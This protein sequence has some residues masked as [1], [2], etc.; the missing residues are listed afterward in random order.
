MET[1]GKTSV[2]IWK[3]S[4]REDTLA[5]RSLQVVRK[6]LQSLIEERFTTTSS[7][8]MCKHGSIG[9]N[10]LPKKR[11]TTSP[12]AP[13]F[14]TLLWQQS[15]PC[16]TATFK[17][18]AFWTKS[19][20]FSAVQQAQA[21]QFTFKMSF[22]PDCQRRIL[23]QLRLDSQPRLIATRF[24]ILSILNWNKGERVCSLHLTRNVL[25]SLLMIWICLRLKSM[26][27]NH[28]LKSCVSSWTKEAGTIA[29]ITSIRSERSMTAWLFLPWDLQVVESHSLLQGSKDISTWL[30]SPTLKTEQWNKSSAICSSGISNKAASLKKF[31][32]W[33]QSS[34]RQL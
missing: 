14:K 19:R 9:N 21:N 29:K 26:V 28:Q 18:T 13:K 15:T 12:K 6:C 4:M 25:S 31:K 1:I 20:L 3:V 34:W 8:V 11:L 32:T 17:S 7:T 23:I 2:S 16:V 30:V 27:P 33:S 24:R 22:C 10:L 5:L